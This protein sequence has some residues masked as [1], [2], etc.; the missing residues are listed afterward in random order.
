MTCIP[1]GAFKKDFHNPNT[2]AIHNYYV[3]EDLSQT[4]YAMSALEVLQSFPTQ[5]KA[6]L[7]TLGSTE[8]CNPGT[9]MLDTTDLKPHLP[10]HIAFQIVVDYPTKCFTW[11]IFHTVVD[12]G[13]STCIMLLAC[14]KA[15]GQPILSPSPTLLTS[16]NDH[17]FRPDGIIPSFPMQLEGK[18]MCVE[19]EVLDAPLDYNLL[20]GWSCTYSMQAVVATVF[21]V[22]LFPHE[23]RIV[24]IDQLSFSIP[25]PDLGASMVSMIDNP[26]PGVVNVGVGLF[27]SLMGTFDYPP[28]QGNIKFISNHHKVEIFQDS[29]FRMTYFKDPWILPSPSATMDETGHPSMSMPLSVAKVAYSLVQQ[30]STNTDPTPTQE[31]DPLLDPI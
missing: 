12:K 23:G 25:D 18:T 27:P 7:T 10:Y 4:P 22:F 24:T 29:S 14:W 5:R 8:T 9:I 11:N 1:K 30:A 6:L 2:R 3:V 16:F 19:V 17:S 28:P 15:I 20:L 21:W 13:A 31:L 26:Q